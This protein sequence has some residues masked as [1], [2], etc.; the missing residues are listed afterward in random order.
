M[1]RLS[2]E[3]GWRHA[4]AAVGTSQGGCPGTMG[5]R[6]QQPAPGRGRR[7]RQTWAARTGSVR[8]LRRHGAVGSSQKECGG[9]NASVE[10]LMD[11]PQRGWKAR[12]CV[13]GER[14]LRQME[15]QQWPRAVSYPSGEGQTGGAGRGD[16]GDRVPRVVLPACVITGG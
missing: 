10:G 13:T 15:S 4:A 8:N 9:G 11:Q 3:G 5:R 2:P 7:S 6:G 14:C 16:R 12:T 1:F